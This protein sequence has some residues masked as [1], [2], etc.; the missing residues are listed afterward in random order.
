MTIEEYFGDWSKVIDTKEADKIVRRLAVGK[1]QVCPQIKDIFKAFTLCKLSNLKVVI[2]GQDPYSDLWKGKPRATGI[3]FANPTDT[4]KENYSHS[5]EILMESVIDFSYPHGNI[6]FDPSLEEWEE[7]G[8]LM[9]NSALSC[10]TGR[11]G[12]HRLLW[13]PFMASFLQ[14]LSTYT[15]GI[16]Y[17]LLGSQAQSFAPCISQRFNHIIKARHPSWY[18]RN[19]CPMPHDLWSQIGEILIGMNGEGIQWY[20]EENFLDKQKDEEVFYERY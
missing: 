8:V 20:K 5:L 3:A 12:S 18:A 1:Q 10:I 14:N 13:R 17:V 2:V 4:P 9:V 11:P 16:V 6:T 7:Q 15:N 19:K